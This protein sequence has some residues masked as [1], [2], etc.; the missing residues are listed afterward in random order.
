MIDFFV[1][2]TP[3]GAGSKRAFPIHGKDGRLHVAVT[4]ASGP[5]GAEWRAA[6]RYA[7]ADAVRSNGG[8]LLDGPVM[9]T[10]TFLLRRPRGHVGTRGIRPSAPRFPTVKPDVL[11]LARAV[12]DAMT[13]IVWRDDA[14]VVGESLVKIY[15][16]SAI[17]GVRVQAWGIVGTDPFARPDGK[18]GTA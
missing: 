14:Q 17:G 10:L 7:A 18:G 2:G 12:E 4:D 1:P 6:I 11:K 16:T 15:T 9:L 8:T 13:G 5:K 3:V